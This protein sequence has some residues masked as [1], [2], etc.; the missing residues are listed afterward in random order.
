MQHKNCHEN[1]DLRTVHLTRGPLTINS[2][3]PLSRVPGT[4]NR[5]HRSWGSSP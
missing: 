2:S 4:G 3:D 1:P 5:I